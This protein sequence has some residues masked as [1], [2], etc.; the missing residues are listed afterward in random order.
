[1][2]KSKWL[3]AIPIVALVLIVVA[4]I[5][6]QFTPKN[7]NTQQEYTPTGNEVLVTLNGT[8]ILSS[9]FTPYLGFWSMVYGDSIGEDDYEDFLSHVLEQYLRER[10]QIEYVTSIGVTIDD[11]TLETE[12]YYSLYELFYDEEEQHAREE[13]FGFSEDTI[14]QIL[15]GY[16]YDD[17][18]VRQLMDEI[19]ATYSEE[20]LYA[21][22]EEYQYY[23]YNSDEGVSVSHI[24]VESED[25]AIETLARL[26][27]GEDFAALARE[28]SIDYGSAING[29]K[30]EPFTVDG[31]LVPEFIEASFGLT[32][33]GELSDIVPSSYGY[34]II[35][36]N[37]RYEEGS[38]LNYEDARDYL[39]YIIA[40]DVR[41]AQF[42]DLWYFAETAYA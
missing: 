14:R 10:L 7:N 31:N 30:L 24:L 40:G 18:Y 36:L 21:A 28:I 20:D 39:P 19:A 41:N 8:E 35:K 6:Y 33:P 37:A 26:A 22:Y 11:E 32:E 34:H 15:R 1:M 13:E 3:N 23:F 16:L 2:N 27:A 4:I 42:E 25:E 17:A 5:V 29:G 38:I 12:L 9:E